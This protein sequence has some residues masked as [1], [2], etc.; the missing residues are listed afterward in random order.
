MTEPANA[1]A[2][3]EAGVPVALSTD[4]N[5]GSSP[6]E[7]LPFIMNLA[8]L[9][10][11]MTPEEVLA[12]STINAAHAIGRAKDIGSIE[13]GKNADL[14]LFDAPNYQTLQYNYAVNRVDTVMKAGKIVVEGGVL[15]E[16][17]D[18]QR[19]SLATEN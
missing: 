18:N 9:T 7:S 6:T 10:M 12:A 13:A 2:M 4:R 14:V 11:K 5:P 16:K 1:R 15:L 3:I 8:C 19:C 17:T